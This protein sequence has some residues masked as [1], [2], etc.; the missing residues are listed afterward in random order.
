M[1]RLLLPKGYRS[2][3]AVLKR[4]HTKPEVEFV[5]RGERRALNLFHSMAERVPAYKDFL[6]QNKVEHTHIRTISDFAQLP[7][8]D[9]DNYLRKY[10]KEALCWDGEF[11]HGRWVISTTS[12]STGTPYYFP[13]EASQDWQY[14]LSAELYL[15]NNFQVQNKTTL[16]IVAFPMGAW[17][18]G[19]YT[20]EAL[21]IVADHGGYNLSI[22]TPGIHKQEVINAVK[23]LGGSFDQII[24]GA[25]APFLKDILDDGAREGIKWSDYNLGFVFSA[26]A[27]SE[28]FRD[29]VATITQ[30]ENEF[31]FS[32]NHYGTVDL[33]TMAHETPESVL[34]RRK[35]ALDNQ[36][37]QLLPEENRQ[38]TFAQYNPELFYFEAVNNSL[39]CSAYSGIPLVRYDLKDYGGV[40]RRSDIQARLPIDK[41][42]KESNLEETTWNLP[43]VY[44]YERND[45]SVSYYAFLIYPDTIRRALQDP[46]LQT[47]LTGKFSMFV[48]FD[49]TGRQR[50]FVHVECGYNQ[51]HTKE[52]EA[53]VQKIVHKFLVEEVSE[54]RETYKTVGEVVKPNI[55]LWDY[56]DPL[57]F[58]SG[59]K[60]KWV[61]KNK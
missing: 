36:L 30:P 61:M 15:R 47:K 16:Y 18:G 49:K 37:S 20:Y 38:P 9:K 39:I 57:Y 8:L 24:I 50:L 44:I 13:R 14:A 12:G 58:K 60:Q 26:E 43:F 6:K 59:T 2:A 45:F 54:Y 10:P 33:G 29:Y 56:E 53:Q 25:Y 21:K 1:N 41:W 52:L 5:R 28:T 3:E 35:L 46:V 32:L 7:T 40:I 22:I 48:D 34:I 31:T 55:Q 19:L 42:L 11:A 51:K 23:Q 27:F 4:L 17:I